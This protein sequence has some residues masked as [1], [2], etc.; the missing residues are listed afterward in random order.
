MSP[1]RQAAKDN[2]PFLLLVGLVSGGSP[3]VTHL[4]AALV[5][6]DPSTIQPAQGA[7]PS[8]LRAEL[9]PIQQKLESMDGRMHVVETWVEIQ[10]DRERRESR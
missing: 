9:A 6:V 4:I 7:T 3:V 1:I 5:G 10:K 8:Q 2:W